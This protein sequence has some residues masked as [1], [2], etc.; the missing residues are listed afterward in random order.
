VFVLCIITDAISEDDD[1][2]FP[3]NDS[4][5]DT[6]P[7]EVKKVLSLNAVTYYLITIHTVLVV[8]TRL[9]SVLVDTMIHRR[10]CQPDELLDRLVYRFFTGQ[11]PP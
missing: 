4:V 7:L 9:L 8:T 11:S 2:I 1:M 5:P 10:D 3:L 6:D